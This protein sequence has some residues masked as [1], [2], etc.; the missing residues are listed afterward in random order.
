MGCF[1][2][3][4]YGGTSFVDATT[5]CDN[6]NDDVNDCLRSTLS[7]SLSV[8]DVCDKTVAPSNISVLLDVFPSLVPIMIMILSLIVVL[9]QLW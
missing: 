8:H 9:L 3:N 1:Q 5:A 2:S 7:Q 4:Y 6:V